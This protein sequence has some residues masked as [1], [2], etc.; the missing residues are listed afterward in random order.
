MS[1]MSRADRL[2][3]I[4]AVVADPPRVHGGAPGGVWGTSSDC[5]QFMAQHLPENAV[6]LETGLGISTV[7]FA[8]WST[9]HTCVVGSSDQVDALRTYL[10]DHQYPA[11]HV[12]YEIGTSDRVLPNLTLEPLDLFMIDGGH[13]FPVPAIDWYYGSQTLRAGGIVVI[14]DIQLPSVDDF[15]VRFLK[16]D[17]RWTPVGGDHKWLAFR[18]EGDF[19]LSEE[20]SEQA[21]LGRRRQPAVTRLKSA[22]RRRQTQLAEIVKR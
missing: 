19:S 21:F 1:T 20:W 11:D 16:L 15:L 9:R 2:A 14:D 6:T 4:G 18:K 12:S 13:G 8:L 17:P 7:L 5:Y 22:V 10:S 3:S